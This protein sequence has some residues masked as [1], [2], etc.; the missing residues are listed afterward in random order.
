[1]PGQSFLISGSVIELAGYLA[2]A[3]GPVPLMLDLRIAHD[4]FASSSDPS[5]NGHLHYPNA[6]D[7]PLNEAAADKIRQYRAD[8]NNRPSTAISFMPAIASTSGRLHCEF[9]RL[10]F[11]QAHR[12]TDRFFAASG[13]QLA[14]SDRGQFNY[15]RA[16]FSSQL[17][18]KVGNIL[19]KDAAL[20][21]TLSID[22]APIASKSHT[23]PSHSQT[24]RLL[25]SSLSLGVPVP[26]ATQRM[27]GV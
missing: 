3:A 10:L 12:E 13:V 22:G 21:I 11:L 1:M 23:H 25:T 4:R 14:Q 24:T 8:Y 2:Y 18:S 15:R 17:K 19:A 6:L 27:R 5:I 20:W 7:G 9:V 16:A 26:R